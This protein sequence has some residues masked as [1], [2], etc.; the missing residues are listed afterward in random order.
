MLIK[1]VKGLFPQIDESCFIA[2]NATILGDVILEQNCS[3]WY[4][5]VIRG[6]VN[7]IRIGSCTNIQDG[8][9]IHATYQKSST[10][11]GNNVSIGHRA[12]VHGCRIH[13]NVLIG[14][15][16]II[17]DNCVVEKNCIIAAG[18][19]LTEGTHTEEGFLYAGVPARKVKPLSE[20]QI[21]MIE[22]TA[23]NYIKYASWID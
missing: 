17:M 16:S 20:K 4:S 21:Q 9:V 11:I 22:Q 10:H 8:V 2:E 3:V 19:V 1:S 14:M 18:A 7:A 13:D 12:I 15:G 6:D 5:A 23:K